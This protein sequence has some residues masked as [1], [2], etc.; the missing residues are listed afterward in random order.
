MHS[1]IFGPVIALIGWTL[2]IW[3]W[4]Y[5]TRIPAMKAAGIDVANL[6]GG[7]GSDLKKVIPAKQQWPAD[8]YNHLLEQPVLFYAICIVL[9]LMDQ[10]DN[11]NAQIA[12]AYVALR[13]AH[14]LIQVTTNRVIIRFSLFSLATIVLIMLTVHAAMAYWGVSLH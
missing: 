3:L 1:A 11:L 8:N 7:T 9:A 10:G 6:T 2:I 4:M 5:F 13:I 12:W 14:S